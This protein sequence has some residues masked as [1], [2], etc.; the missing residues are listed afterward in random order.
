MYIVLS[1]AGWRD[2]DV[3]DEYRRGSVYTAT[4]GFLELVLGA[5]IDQVGVHGPVYR[6]GQRTSRDGGHGRAGIYG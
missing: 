2:H 3:V 4:E 6:Y 5:I 1:N